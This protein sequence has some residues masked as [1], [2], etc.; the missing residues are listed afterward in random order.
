MDLLDVEFTQEKEGIML[1]H[2]KAG[3]IIYTQE[4]PGQPPEPEYQYPEKLL[5]PKED[6]N[7]LLSAIKKYALKRLN[8]TINKL[9]EKEYEE[10]IENCE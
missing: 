9:A 6:L 8:E 10:Y 7:K 5:I 1:D 2:P 3:E 4:Y